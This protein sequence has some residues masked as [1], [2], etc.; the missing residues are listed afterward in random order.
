MSNEFGPNIDRYPSIGGTFWL[1][2]DRNHAE[3]RHTLRT[4]GA[5]PLHGVGMGIEVAEFNRAV[6]AHYPGLAELIVDTINKEADKGNTLDASLIGG[7]LVSK[8]IEG[9]AR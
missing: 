3:W 7:R 4:K 9:W 6:V 2:T 5:W 1:M 8:R